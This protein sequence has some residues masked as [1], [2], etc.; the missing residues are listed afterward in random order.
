MRRFHTA[1]MD[2]LESAIR[3]SQEQSLLT[4]IGRSYITITARGIGKAV[5]LEE[6]KEFKIKPNKN[7]S[8]LGGGGRRTNKGKDK[9]KTTGKGR[10]TR[11]I[12]SGRKKT[13]RASIPKQSRK[14]E[15]GGKRCQEQ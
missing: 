6:K 14:K 4:G 11:S 9:G 8:T 3:K 7:E 5:L 10:A 13:D 2:H 15:G 12:H 1:G